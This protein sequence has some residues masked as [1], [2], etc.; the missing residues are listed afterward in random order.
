[1]HTTFFRFQGSKRP[2]RLEVCVHEVCGSLLLNPSVAYVL[3]EKEKGKQAMSEAQLTGMAK[4]PCVIHTRLMSFLP[5]PLA[6]VGWW[7]LCEQPSVTLT[8]WLERPDCQ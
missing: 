2:L 7:S 4:L 6:L 3:F 1:M 8:L 5:G